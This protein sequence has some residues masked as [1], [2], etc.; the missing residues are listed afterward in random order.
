MSM[1]WVR[2]VRWLMALLGERIPARQALDWGL[3]NQVF[4]DSEFA[5]RADALLD[6]LE[7]GAEL[8]PPAVQA[9]LERRLPHAR[10][11]RG[12]LGRETFDV[13]QDDRDPQ[14]DRELGKRALEDPLEL[15]V[16]GAGLRARTGR[17][18]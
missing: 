12:V 8:H 18:R 1:R 13:A 5:G 17:I 7:Q 2:P 9:A 16:Q 14:I 15:V 11:C 10:H 4:P 3:I 6:R